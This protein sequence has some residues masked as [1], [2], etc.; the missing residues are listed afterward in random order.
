MLNIYNDW[1]DYIKSNCKHK[2]DFR[3]DRN[4]MTTSIFF[5]LACTCV[6][7]LFTDTFLKC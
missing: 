5:A 1:S 7:V 6:K 4:V 2:S 3:L